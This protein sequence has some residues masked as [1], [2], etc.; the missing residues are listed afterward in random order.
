MAFAVFT[1]SSISTQWNFP[2]ATCCD[3]TTHWLQ[4]QGRES[5][6]LLSQALKRFGKKKKKKKSAVMPLFPLSYI[7]LENILILN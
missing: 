7:I 6:H 1:R 2:E 4:K 5:V 3:I